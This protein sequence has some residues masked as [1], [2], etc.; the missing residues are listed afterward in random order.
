MWQ[1]SPKHPCRSDFSGT[2]IR[3]LGHDP[4][5]RKFSAGDVIKRNGYLE[6]KLNSNEK[7]ILSAWKLDSG[8]GHLTGQVF[9]YKESGEIFNMFYFPLQLLEAKHEFLNYEEIK[10]LSEIHR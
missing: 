3:S 2:F 6:I 9:M 5:I 8:G 4:I 7:V 1:P 10:Q